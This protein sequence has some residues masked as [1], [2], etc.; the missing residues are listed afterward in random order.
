MRTRHD[1]A[2]ALSGAT[3]R[4]RTEHRRNS[5]L[6][7][8]QSGNQGNRPFEVWTTKFDGSSRFYQAYDDYKIAEG[9]RDRLQEIGLACELRI[10]G[11]RA[12]R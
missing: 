9:I 11:K 1:R 3:A 2:A 12:T 8:R 7:P 4:G 5:K 6:T 10:A